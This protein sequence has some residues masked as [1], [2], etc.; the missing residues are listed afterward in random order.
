MGQEQSPASL[1]DVFAIATNGGGYLLAGRAYRDS[2][3]ALEGVSYSAPCLVKLDSQGNWQWSRTYATSHRD[4]GFF[5]SAVQTVNGGFFLAGSYDS[6]PIGWHYGFYNS[7]FLFKTDDSGN[8]Q[9]NQTFSSIDDYHE[10]YS[11]SALITNDSGYAVVG[12]LDG[13]VWLAKF[14]PESTTPPDETSPSQTTWIVAV[15]IIVAVVSIGLIVYFKKRKHKAEITNRVK[16]NY[17]LRYFI[18]N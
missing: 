14:A 1:A 12:G 9:W 15:V 5:S 6:Q 2:R 16:Y 11:S 3:V 8:V 17:N 7:P 13:S 4:S 18:S 10:G